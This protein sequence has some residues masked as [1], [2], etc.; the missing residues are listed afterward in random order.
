[1]SFFGFCLSNFSPG[2]NPLS[3][4]WVSASGVLE[5]YILLISAAPCAEVGGSLLLLPLPVEV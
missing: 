2:G 5:V 1:M 4:V 3:I